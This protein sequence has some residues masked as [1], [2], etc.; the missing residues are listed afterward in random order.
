MQLFDRAR[1]PL[2]DYLHS[3]VFVNVLRVESFV[4]RHQLVGLLLNDRGV[5]LADQGQGLGLA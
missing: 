3:H 4:R 1:H 5:L 2:D